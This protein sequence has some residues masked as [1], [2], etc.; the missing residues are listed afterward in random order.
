MDVSTIWYLIIGTLLI[1]IGLTSSYFAKLPVTTSIVYFLMG[2]L[3]GNHGLHFIKFD[4]IHDAK[5]FEKLTE[6]VVLV[7]LFSAGLKLRLPFGDTRWASCWRLATFSMLITIGLITLFAV[8]FLKMPL[9][10]AVLLGAILA[11][12]DPVLASDVQVAHEEDR[13]RLRFSLTGEAGLNDGTAFPFVILGLGLLGLDSL[14]SSGLQWFSKDLLWAGV[15]GLTI[16]WILGSL[17]SKVVLKLR[18]RNEETLIL[19]DFLAIGLVALAYG[20]AVSVG[21]YGFLSVFAAGLAMRKIE[22]HPTG[23]PVASSQEGPRT[24]AKAV[25]SF[26]EQMERIG[27][28]FVVLLLGAV[29]NLESFLSGDFLIIPVLFLL[30][31]PVAVY[32]GLGRI[33]MGHFRRPLISWFGIRGIGSIYY[34]T[35]ALGHGLPSDL[36]ARLTAITYATVVCS[37]FAHGISGLP[38]MNFYQ[39]RRR[40][41]KMRPPGTQ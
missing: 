21:T 8:Y 13:D 36:G 30:I 22:K 18:T 12:T 2:V 11:P 34:L 33:H 29:L 39:E 1:L 32:V 16:G 15:G 38:F 25:L 10:L 7:S 14:G 35:Y 6:V 19:D 3:L 27:E 31:R 17:V 5:F 23:E 37:I 28:V 24:I 40:V 41:M 20:F 9:G 26:S 4:L